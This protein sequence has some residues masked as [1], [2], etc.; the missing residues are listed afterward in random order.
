MRT[1][2]LYKCWV[3]EN[4]SVITAN[5]NSYN[6]SLQSLGKTNK[7]V[8]YIHHHIRVPT[9]RMRVNHNMRQ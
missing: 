9:L 5:M 1:G 6:A 7:K 8:R 4:I 2:E 3:S